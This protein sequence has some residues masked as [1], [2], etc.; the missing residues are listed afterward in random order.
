MLRIVDSVILISLN[1]RVSFISSTL[2][3]YGYKPRLL[4]FQTKQE[5]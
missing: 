3:D 4:L 1:Y 2:I 5:F